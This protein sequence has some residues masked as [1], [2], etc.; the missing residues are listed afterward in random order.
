[1]FNVKDAKLV[2]H[3]IIKKLFNPILN[4][5]SLIFTHFLVY[6]TWEICVI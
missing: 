4:M 2:E 5:T 3:N 6:K 1:M